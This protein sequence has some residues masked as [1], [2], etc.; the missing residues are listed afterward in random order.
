MGFGEEAIASIQPRSDLP[1]GFNFGLGMSGSSLDYSMG[2]V[3]IGGD[4][5]GYV[6]RPIGLGGIVTPLARVVWTA[7]RSDTLSLGLVADVTSFPIP[8]V[9][10]DRVS[11]FA[12]I[13]IGELGVAM[14]L[15]FNCPIVFG[16]LVPMTLSPSILFRGDEYNNVIF[17]PST[18]LELAAR[19]MPD[20][21]LTLGGGNVIGLRYKI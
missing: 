2:A 18:N 16:K 7:H 4:V 14:S 20:L 12:N 1:Q 3:A 19:I 5:K 13:P 8:V 9:T 17:G 21:E 15:H 11:T 10:Q 6:L